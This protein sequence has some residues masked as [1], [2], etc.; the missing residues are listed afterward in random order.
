[1]IK[2]AENLA[3]GDEFEDADG[4]TY[5]VTHREP[6]PEALTQ[7][8]TYNVAHPLTAPIRWEFT[9]GTPITVKEADRG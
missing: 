3:R 1:M 7:V 2:Y 4:N 6:L 8:L 9:N 5:R